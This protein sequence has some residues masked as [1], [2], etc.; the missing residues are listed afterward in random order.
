MANTRF[1]IEKLVFTI[2]ADIQLLKSKLGTYG[3]SQDGIRNVAETLKDISQAVEKLSMRPVSEADAVILRLEG[4][5]DIIRAFGQLQEKAKTMA[6]EVS[7]AAYRNAEDAVWFVQL[8][9]LETMANDPKTETPFSAWA[10]TTGS[11]KNVN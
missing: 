7:K 4:L 6:A 8:R 1:Q 9:E 11:R 5:R 3:L 2:D 10:P